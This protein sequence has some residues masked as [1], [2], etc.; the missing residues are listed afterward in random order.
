MFIWH[1][2]TTTTTTEEK[3]KTDIEILKGLAV[4][5]LD[6]RGKALDLVVR[7][8][9][10]CGRVGHHSGRLCGWGGQIRDHVPHHEAAKLLVRLVDLVGGCG[11]MHEQSRK[12]RKKKQSRSE[13]T[14]RRR[15]ETTPLRMSQLICTPESEVAVQPARWKSSSVSS[16]ERCGRWDPVRGAPLRMAK[17]MLVTTSS[18]WVNGM[19]G[20]RMC[21]HRKEATCGGRWKRVKRGRKAAHSFPGLEHVLVE[22]GEAA[23]SHH[24]AARRR[25]VQGGRGNGAALGG[26]LVENVAHR[27]CT[28]FL[29][30]L[31]SKGDSMTERKRKRGKER[32]S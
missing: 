20:S 14:G 5:V 32:E 4:R 27:L 10:P 12:K 26:D 25:G 11:V 19:F 18:C 24:Q 7:L 17:R 2:T 8:L 30:S 29:I 31:F 15:R 9:R 3:G 21:E 1:K 28:R 6:L 13:K 16:G 23:D 22:P